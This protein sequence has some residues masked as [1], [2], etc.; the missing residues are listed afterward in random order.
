M[1]KGS[2]KLEIISKDPRMRRDYKLTA[3]TKFKDFYDYFI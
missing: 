3:N 1:M 2:L